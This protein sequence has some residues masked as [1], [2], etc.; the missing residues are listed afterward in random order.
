MQTYH[1]ADAVLLITRLT[2]YCVINSRKD[3]LEKI[4]DC[5]CVRTLVGELTGRFIHPDNPVNFNV[6]FWNVISHIEKQKAEK[7]AAEKAEFEKRQK[8]LMALAVET[9]MENLTKAALK[10]INKRTLKAEWGLSMSDLS[11]KE[12]KKL[13]QPKNK[14]G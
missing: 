9:D 1:S 7:E 11:F 2:A 10:R 13:Q 6:D 12:W 14:E 8:Q 4:V 5:T 3:I